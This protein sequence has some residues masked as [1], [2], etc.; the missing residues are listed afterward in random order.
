MA[1][2]VNNDIVASLKAVSNDMTPVDAL[3]AW[4][5]DTANPI[6]DVG[7]FKKA[8]KVNGFASRLKRLYVHQNNYSEAEEYMIDIDREWAI[9]P[10]GEEE[11]PS[12]RGVAIQEITNSAEIAEGAYL[13]IDDRPAF[14]PMDIYAYRPEGFSIDSKFRMINVYRYKEQMYPHNEVVEFVGETLYAIKKPNSVTYKAS[15]I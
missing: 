15:A 1:R 9:N 8:F 3:A 7:R 11:V 6:K 14:R 5:L 12:I 10:R 2:K 13:G 4:D